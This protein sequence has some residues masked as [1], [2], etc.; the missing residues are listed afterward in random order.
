L[1]NIP[2]KTLEGQRIRK[3][4]VPSFENYS[5][6]SADYSQIELRVMAHLSN[7]EGM[8]NAF[9]NN[10]DIHTA[11]ASKIYKV[12]IESVTKTMRNNA[13]SANFGI[14]YG[15]S[16]FGLSQ[17]LSITRSEANTLITEYFNS[18][19][20]VKIFMDNSIE[21]AR[22]KG[23]VVTLFDRKRKIENI[24]SNNS[25]LAGNAARNAI[26]TPVQGTAA[27]IIKISMIK[28][29]EKLK[30]EHPDVKMILQ[31][32]DELVFETPTHKA[33]E[34]AKIIK[35]TMENA[36]ELSIPIIAESKFAKTWFEAH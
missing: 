12:P 28:C 35:N 10:E 17:N 24:N 1:Q 26:N 32:H 19:P 27:D 6:I 7:D 16:S 9:L 21:N 34:V 3:C 11:T 30:I 2:I 4:F 33:E 22:Q 15:I 20:K 14:I 23:F 36:I 13:K 31:V 25:L 18:Y 5:L 29:Y 8:I